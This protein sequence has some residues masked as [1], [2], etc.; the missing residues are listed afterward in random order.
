MKA[1]FAGG[2]AMMVCLFPPR[3]MEAQLTEKIMVGGGKFCMKTL[4]NW[5]N[6]VLHDNRKYSD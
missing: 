5:R 3:K 2:F 1:A 6:V 4:G